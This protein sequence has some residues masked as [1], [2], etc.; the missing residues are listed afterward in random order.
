VF[1]DHPSAFALASAIYE[2]VARAHPN[3]YLGG[4]PSE[5]R[6]PDDPELSYTTIDGRFDL[7]AIASGLLARFRI[8][9]RR[10]P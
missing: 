2:E 6:D 7:V 3:A 1:D 9:E 8:E 5:D 4:P 10:E